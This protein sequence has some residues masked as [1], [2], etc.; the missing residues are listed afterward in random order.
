MKQFVGNLPGGEAVYATDELIAMRGMD[1]L[2]REL[3]ETHWWRAGLVPPGW[4]KVRTNLF[5]GSYV[6][7]R[8]PSQEAAVRLWCERNEPKRNA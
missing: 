8:A 4:H 3:V 1:E 2:R 5:N 6:A 7:V